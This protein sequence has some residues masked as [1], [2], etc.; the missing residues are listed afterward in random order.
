MKQLSEALKINTSLDTLNL[1][2][3][4]SHYITPFIETFKCNKSLTSFYMPKYTL[5]KK[6]SSN[7]PINDILN[8]NTTLTELEY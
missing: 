3:L 5:S 1:K 7:D 2:T 8:Y 6:I 4:K